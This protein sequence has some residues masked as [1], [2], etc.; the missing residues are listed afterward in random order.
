MKGIISAKQ[1]PTLRKRL[2]GRIVLGTGCFD[3]LHVGHLYFLH[4]AANQGDVLVVGLNSDRS[5]KEIKGSKRPIVTEQERATLISEF[6]CVDFVF[7]YDNISAIDE[8][9]SLKP[10]VFVIGEGSLTDYQDE[11]DA[12]RDVGARLHI[13]KRMS[14]PSTTSIVAGIQNSS[15]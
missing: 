15:K 9:R 5:I 11:V 4:E 13:I 3:I 7:I 6:K 14:T 12:T 10:D 8:I 2:K 1:L